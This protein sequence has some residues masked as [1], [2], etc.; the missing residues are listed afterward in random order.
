VV[1]ISSS[2]STIASTLLLAGSSNQMLRSPTMRGVQSAGHASYATLILST[3]DVQ[4]G[5][6]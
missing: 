1:L 4:L 5:G 6:M 2:R 3:P